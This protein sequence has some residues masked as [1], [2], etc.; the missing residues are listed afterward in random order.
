[1]MAK[2]AKLVKGSVA[3]KIAK[4]VVSRHKLQVAGHSGGG[5]KNGGGDG[6]E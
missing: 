1:M 6:G 3:A 5:E 4:C 2:L